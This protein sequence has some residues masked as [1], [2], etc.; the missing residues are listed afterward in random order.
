MDI[1]IGDVV[2]VHDDIDLP[3]G[4]IKVKIGGGTAG[5]KGLKSIRDMLGSSDFIRVRIGID[6][7]GG[8]KD[9]TDYVLGRISPAESVILENEVFPVATEALLVILTENAQV[10]MNAFNG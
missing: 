8:S 10:A 1:D 2:V 5:H 4:K 7:P 6:R 3:L 9:I